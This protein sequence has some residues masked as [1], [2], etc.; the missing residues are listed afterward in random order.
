M[1]SH[2]ISS[3]LLGVL[4]LAACGQTAVAPS[5]PGARL[6]VSDVAR[7]E[8]P[9]DVP[10]DAAATDIA[11]FGHDLLVELEPS[12]NV[13]VSP[14]SIATAFAMLR[15]A[16]RGA[17]A[18]EIDAVM[19]F[20]AERLGPT[21]NALTRGWETGEPA[22][23]DDPDLAIANALWAKEDLTLEPS[24]LDAVKADFGAGVRTVDFTSPRA[25]KEIDVWV[26]EQTRDRIEEL[27]DE[28]DPD[29]TL[30]LANAVC[31]KA[32]WEDEFDA[33]M[34]RE[35]DFT[36][37]DGSVVQAETMQ[38]DGPRDRAS[39]DGWTAVRLPYARSE[40]SMWVLLPDEG[41]D[42]APVDL[43]APAVLA[44]A[45]DVAEPRDVHLVLPRWDFQTDKPLNDPLQVL[46]MV[47]PFSGDADFSAA[48][49][50]GVIG[51]VIHRADITV[52]EKGTEAAAVT[53]IGME[54]SAVQIPSLSFEAD[55]PFAFAIVDD[56]TGTPIFEGVVADPTAG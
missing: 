15:P 48:G 17:T 19:H 23:D 49:D 25:K 22:T 42:L 21:F 10:V 34:T 8:P 11:T 26:Q 39:G 30:V 56:T 51:Q 44:E 12:G 53:G 31:L 50:L 7:A 40:L 32:T 13:V 43:L 20:Q 28:I 18:E 29:T 5:T 9:A 46:G 16:A 55:R 6:Q 54:E 41:A 24:Y 14:A 33:A 45:R 36:L 4:A 27:F 38:A 35:A 37:A 1:T 2:R 47:T 3:A 52:D